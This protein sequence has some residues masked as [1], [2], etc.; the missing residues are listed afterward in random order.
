MAKPI[1]TLTLFVLGGE[2]QDL[3]W[4]YL[5]WQREVIQTP[6]VHSWY[7]NDWC[8]AQFL[9]SFQYFGPFKKEK[10]LETGN[11]KYLNMCVKEAKHNKEL[12]RKKKWIVITSEKVPPYMPLASLPGLIHN[13]LLLLFP[14]AWE[15]TAEVEESSPCVSTCRAQNFT[16]LL[17]V[18][19][20]IIHIIHCL[21]TNNIEPYTIQN[22]V[23]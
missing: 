9:T 17:Y 4:K 13:V 18:N 8:S 20:C 15:S 16:T 1:I 12:T 2:Q 11:F 6:P 5:L 7:Q 23:Q 3:V 22:G 21:A 19:L 10:I 14:F